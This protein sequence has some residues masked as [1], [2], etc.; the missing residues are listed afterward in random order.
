MLIQIQI[1]IYVP[2]K[3]K[4]RFQ[5]AIENITEAVKEEFP[6]L[7]VDRMHSP[8]TVTIKDMEEQV[9]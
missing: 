4:E 5:D 7:K 2:D 8:V 1:V 6:D 9:L 3:D